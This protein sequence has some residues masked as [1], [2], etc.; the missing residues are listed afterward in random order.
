M[1]VTAELLEF[2]PTAGT[3]QL[4]FAMLL[5]QLVAVAIV[6]FPPIEH[7]VKLDL[8]TEDGAAPWRRMP[9]PYRSIHGEEAVWTPPADPAAWHVLDILPDGRMRLDGADI[10]LAAL[11]DRIEEISYGTKWV[12]VRPHPEARYEAFAEAIAAVRGSGLWR[13]RLASRRFAGALD[14]ERR[15]SADDPAEGAAAVR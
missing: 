13:L 15:V 7:G 1:R 12:D 5:A 3:A 6:V 8:P 11:A 4:L 2:P 14:E 9:A 10:A